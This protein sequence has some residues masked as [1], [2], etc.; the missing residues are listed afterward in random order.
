MKRIQ[1]LGVEHVIVIQF[2]ESYI[3]TKYELFYSRY[4]TKPC[5]IF[6]GQDFKFGKSGGQYRC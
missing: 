2:D 6:F 1:S 5:K 4:K 3:I